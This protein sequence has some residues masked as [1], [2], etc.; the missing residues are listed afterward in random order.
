MQELPLNEI[1]FLRE[2]FETLGPSAR[3]CFDTF[4]AT[5]LVSKVEDIRLAAF[6]HPLEIITKLVNKSETTH[7]S[8]EIISVRSKDETRRHSVNEFGSVAIARICFEAW[9]DTMNEEP[10]SSRMF[11]LFTAFSRRILVG[12][13]FEGDGS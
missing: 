11:A 8:H 1:H 12:V 7:A 13:L 6:D 2:V 10:E 9:K 4:D 3:S 5:D